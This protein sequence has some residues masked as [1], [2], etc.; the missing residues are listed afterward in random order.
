[1]T[2]TRWESGVDD[3]RQLVRRTDGIWTY[4]PRSLWFLFLQLSKRKGHVVPY[5]ILFSH[6]NSYSLGR[7]NTRQLRKRLV[8]SRWIIRTHR[9]IGLEL[10]DATE[11]V[12]QI[13]RTRSLG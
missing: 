3:E 8:G 6:Q 1:M 5:K 9:A 7:E 10:L 4:I 11:D 2:D 12:S 13:V